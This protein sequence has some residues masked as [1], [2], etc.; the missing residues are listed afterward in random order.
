MLLVDLDTQGHAGKSLGHRRAHA[1]SPTSFDWLTDRTMAP[2]ARWRGR[3]RSPGCRGARVQA[4]G[5]LAAGAG[6]RAAPRRERLRERL[7]ECGSE[8]RRGHL[9]R[10]AVAGAERRPTS[11]WPRR[12]GGAGRADLPALDGCAEMV[13]DGAS[14]SPRSTSRPELRV[15]AGGADAV[16]E[17]RAGRRD[18]RAK[19]EHYFPGRCAAAAGRQRGHRRGPEPRQDHLGV[20]ALEPRRELLQAVAEDVE[21]WAGGRRA[22]AGRGLGASSLRARRS[23]SRAPRCAAP[24][25]RGRGRA[26]AGCRPRSRPPASPARRPSLPVF[27]GALGP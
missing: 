12:G 2:G 16:P 26:P 24:A 27:E 4:D 20:R 18:P 15:I 1:A 19:L 11:W 8:L 25:R 23:S 14:R 22:A 7:D 5:R 10:A 13:R 3:P 6:E 9:R 21:R 17:D